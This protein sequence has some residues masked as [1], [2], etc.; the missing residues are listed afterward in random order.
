MKKCF[1]YVNIILVQ[2]IAFDT[3]TAG[4]ENIEGVE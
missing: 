4:K 2:N 3:A 1:N